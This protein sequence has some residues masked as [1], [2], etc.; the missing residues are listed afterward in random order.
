MLPIP[1]PPARATRIPGGA[2]LTATV[3]EETA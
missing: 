1:V 3:R 2:S